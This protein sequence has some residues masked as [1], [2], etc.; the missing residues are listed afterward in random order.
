L[1]KKIS[2][3]VIESLIRLSGILVILFVFLIFIFLLRD[4]LSLFRVYRVGEFL[5]GRNWHPISEPP[6]F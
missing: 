3:Y 6:E 2:E 5:F 4:S 1:R